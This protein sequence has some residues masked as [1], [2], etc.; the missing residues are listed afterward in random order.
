MVVAR[1]QL[2]VC[3]EPLRHRQPA[4]ATV[5][6]VHHPPMPTRPIRPGRARYPN[7][8]RAN[9]ALDP[10]A[11]VELVTL[12]RQRDPRARPSPTADRHHLHHPIAVERIRGQLPVR[13]LLHKLNA[14]SRPDEAVLADLAAIV[15]MLDNHGPP[16]GVDPERARP[17]PPRSPNDPAS[18]DEDE[19][20]PAPVANRS[21]TPTAPESAR[22]PPRDTP[23]P[24]PRSRPKR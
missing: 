6:V 7:L 9:G 2:G 8:V 10:T 23:P 20:T 22:R 11:R 24:T 18:P 3:H 19:A 13:A 21:S 16:P 1:R 15:Q 17:P 4:I 14:I 12:H 5:A